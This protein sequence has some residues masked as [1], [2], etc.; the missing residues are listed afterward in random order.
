MTPLGRAL[1]EAWPY[2]FALLFGVLFGVL[3]AVYRYGTLD[4]ATLLIAIVGIS[5]P[6][7]V[8]ASFTTIA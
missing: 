1:V 7:F 3:G 8:V 2:L 6:S 5:V 4:Y